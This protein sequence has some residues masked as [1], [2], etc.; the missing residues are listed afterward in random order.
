M[1]NLQI[2]GGLSVSNLGLNVEGGITVNSGGLKIDDG[3]A[4]INTITSV[5]GTLSVSPGMI[6][7]S[8][9]TYHD[10]VMFISYHDRTIS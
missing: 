10:H 1:T 2:T 7:V 4:T 6:K 3:S 5:G 8:I 9:R